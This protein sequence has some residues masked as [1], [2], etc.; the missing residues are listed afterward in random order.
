MQEMDGIE[1]AFISVVVVSF[2]ALVAAVM[3]MALT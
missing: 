2:L 1:R 3:A